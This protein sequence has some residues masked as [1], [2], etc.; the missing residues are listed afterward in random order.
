MVQL[1][2]TVIPVPTSDS[3]IVVRVVPVMNTILIQEIQSAHNV[4]TPALIVRG[5]ESINAYLVMIN[6]SEL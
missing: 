2:Q 5:Q 6:R 4:T 3:S 1:K